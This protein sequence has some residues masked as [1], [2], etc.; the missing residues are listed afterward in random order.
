[1][2]NIFSSFTNIK[3]FNYFIQIIPI[4]QKTL[5]CFYH[6]FFIICVFHTKN[7]FIIRIRRNKFILEFRFYPFLMTFIFYY[8]NNFIYIKFIFFLFR[9]TNSSAFDRI[10][11]NFLK[12]FCPL[13]AKIFCIFD[14]NI[15]I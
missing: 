1:M 10:I 11:M 2:Q 3:N 9:N 12:K 7:I 15:I 13:L 6:I 14:I 5:F 8:I 4:F